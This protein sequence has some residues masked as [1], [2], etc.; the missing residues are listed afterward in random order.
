VLLRA[1]AAIML[2]NLLAVAMIG[3]VIPV[4]AFAFFMSMMWAPLAKFTSFKELILVCCVYTVAMTVLSTSTI[5]AQYN[6]GMSMIS[7][8]H[9]LE[10]QLT[11]VISISAASTYYNIGYFAIGPIILMFDAVMMSIIIK[12]FS[13]FSISQRLLGSKI[14][15]LKN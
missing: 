10:P 1:I 13:R 9:N 15:G 2:S 14:N 7:N 12:I 4:P 5:L 11:N 8:L 6:I 3:S